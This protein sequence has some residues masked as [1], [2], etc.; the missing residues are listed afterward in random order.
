MTSELSGFLLSFACGAAIMVM[1][2]FLGAISQLAKSR[3]L[4][5]FFDI[6]WWIFACILFSMAMWYATSLRLRIFDFLALGIG[7]IICSYTMKKPLDYIFCAFF[8][9]IS[10][11]IGFIFIIL[12]TPWTILYKI[13]IVPIRNRMF[14]RRKVANDDTPEGCG[15]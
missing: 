11:I 9:L 4:D 7:A 6:I 2:Y 3:V 10:K 8:Q 15:S 1:W 12:L 5:F 14:K 13:L